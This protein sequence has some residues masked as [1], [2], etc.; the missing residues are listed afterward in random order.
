MPYMLLHIK[1]ADYAKW[2]PAFD[3]NSANR[4]ASGSQG[5]QLFRSAM[6]PMN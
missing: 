6:I 3:G 4:R 5:G 1:V 2:K